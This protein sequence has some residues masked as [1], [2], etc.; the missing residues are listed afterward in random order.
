MIDDWKVITL[1]PCLGIVRLRRSPETPDI[2]QQFQH[3]WVEP[4]DEKCVEGLIVH[5]SHQVH[6]EEVEG[7]DPADGTDDDVQQHF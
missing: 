7:D 6:Q 4:K 5:A 3:N 2:K 1:N